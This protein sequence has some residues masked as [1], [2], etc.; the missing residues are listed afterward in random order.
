MRLEIALSAAAMTGAKLVIAATAAVYVAGVIYNID[1]F[2]ILL[3]A[4]PGIRSG[5]IG[6]SFM[7]PLALVPVWKIGLVNWALRG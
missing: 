3:V 5:L 4:Y 7:W 2:W 6:F 1:H